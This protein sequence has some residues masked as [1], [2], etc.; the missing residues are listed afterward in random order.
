MMVMTMT[1]MRIRSQDDHDPDEL[2]AGLGSSDAKSDV[3]AL[4]FVTYA[5]PRP[6]K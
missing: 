3:L 4:P 6:Y 1:M 2:V 5:V